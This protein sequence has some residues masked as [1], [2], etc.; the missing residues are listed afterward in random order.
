MAR[1]LVPLF[2][3]FLLSITTVSAQPASLREQQDYAFAL[4]LFEDGSYHMALIKF[5]QFVA[6]FPASDLRVDAEYYV[7]ESQYQSAALSDA[8]LAFARFQKDHPDSKLA[9]D[10]GFREGE[11]YYRQGNFQKAFEQFSTVVRSWPRGNLAHESAYW[12]GESAFRMEQ[13]EDALRYYRISYEH[14]P[15][16][17]IRDY[18]F[19]STG[20]VREKQE[21]HDEALAVYEEFLNLFPESALRSSVFT[22]KGAC[23]FQRKEF[24]QSLAWLESLTD[25]PDPDNAAE[26]LFLRAESQY[27]LGRHAEAESLYQSFLQAYPGN[28]RAKQVQYALGW[29]QIEQQKYSD[30]V[31]TFDALSQKDGE[32]AEAAAFR[33][34]VALRLNGQL[35][36]ARMVFDGIIARKSDG[37]YTDN[38]HFELGMAAYNEK[39]YD[40]AMTHFSTVATGFPQSD[41]LSDSWYMLGETRLKQGQASEAAEAFGS[42]ASIAD[43]NPDIVAKALFRQGFSLHKAARYP[44]AVIVLKNFTQRYPDHAYRAEGLTWLAESHFK[45]EEFEAAEAAYMQALESTR[46]SAITQD[47][48]YGLGWTQFRMQN[49]A[50]AVPTFQRLTTEFRAGKHD[51]D[52]NVRLG[53]AQYALKRFEDA[54]KTYRYTS[55]MYP[56]NPLTAYALLQLASCEHRLGNTPSAIST[57]RGM[58]ARYADSEYADKAQFSLAW[59]YFQ[60]RDYDVALTEFHK[61]ISTWPASPL[62][63]QTKYTIADCHY[64]K[65]DYANAE[66]AY[67]RVLDE[68]PDSPIVSD[69]LDGLAQTL[70]MRGQNDA[71]DRVKADWLGAHPSGSGAENV[72]FAEVRS[73]AA[74]PDAAKAI[75]LLQRFIAAYPNGAH[76]QEAHVLLGR[77][78]RENGDLEEARKTLREGYAID[79]SSEQAVEALF[80]LT[81]TAMQLQDRSTAMQH[82][83][84]ILAHP[85]GRAHKARAL[86]R[87]GLS[88]RSEKKFVEARSDFSA[89]KAAQPGEKFAVLSEIELALLD[90]E[91]GSLDKA[92][93][94]LDAVAASRSDAVAAEAQ[95]RKGELL[96]G[97]AR[98]EQAEEALLRVGYVFPDAMP[99]TARA[100]LRLGML[101]EE[102]GKNAQARSVYERITAEFAGS[103]EARTAARKLETLR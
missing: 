43:A 69:A 90:A 59:M 36:A 12:A 46:D 70:R 84:E 40:R 38:A 24:E 85:R 45:T 14:Y 89:A 78:Y 30:A 95:Y 15:E 23:L 47:A 17:R 60:S 66:A 53:D 99:W 96:A 49:F 101:H 20:F 94:A 32:I 92:V 42:A 7:A 73:A 9:D 93:A 35:D 8:A 44:A 25:S 72:E 27:K 18:A 19:F 16:G 86:Y 71:A 4:G 74:Q 64:N 52:A 11:V 81:E 21:R 50:A 33:K 57:L 1:P 82:C 80:E 63:A 76:R 5:R 83:E 3:L 87:R 29:T 37:A 68:H 6:D 31:S 103:D 75:P 79:R 98:P 26:R 55:R 62:L 100:L 13:Y 77:V 54:A 97:A 28:A 65:G 61:L 39:L 56:A 34:G 41:V 2:F 22:R 10:A 51:V 67:R 88:F 58:L 91:E 48:L 102:L